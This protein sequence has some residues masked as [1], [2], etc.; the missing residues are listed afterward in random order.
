[1]EVVVDQQEVGDPSLF[2]ARETV[3]FISF[4]SVSLRHF[5]IQPPGFREIL[6][7][8]EQGKANLVITKDDCVN[9]ELKSESP[10]KSRVL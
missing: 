8:L 2:A 9:L 10:Q 7:Q 3:D 6:R 1:M 4:S 5:I